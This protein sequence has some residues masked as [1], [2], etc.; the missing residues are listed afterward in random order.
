MTSAK[1]RILGLV[2]AAGN[3]LRIA[4]L[5]MS[6]E[7]YPIGFGVASEA[8]S[9]S[10]V[11]S[12]YLLERMATAGV[13]EAFIVIRPGKWDIPA[14]FGDGRSVGLRLAYLTVDVPFG[15]P[16]T[17][18]QAYPFIKDATVALGFP[19]LLFWP[20][21]GFRVLL[22]RLRISEA[23]VVLGLFPT[24]EPKR[25]GIVDLSD[26]GGVLGIYEKSAR[27]DLPFMWGI[28]V[29]RPTFT[30]FLHAHVTIQREAIR[31]ASLSVATD[32]YGSAKE[33]PI[34]DVV[35]AGIRSGLRVEAEILSGGR[36]MDI[37]TPEGLR[38]ALALHLG[39]TEP[40]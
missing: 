22:E 24:D 13:S 40:T 29:W 11:V 25:V 30:E 9:G 28:A 5:P 27:T 36:Y 33:L 20:E 6:K 32:S 7:L 31:Q 17:L 21:T 23:D 37:G 38:Q 15:V 35:H 2:P 8:H 16:F 1:T 3:A 10:K 12:Q 18:V 26:D 39:S 14:F 34:G 19:D 4:P